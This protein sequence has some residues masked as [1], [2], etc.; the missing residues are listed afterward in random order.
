VYV[1]IRGCGVRVAMPSRISSHFCD[2]V[3]ARMDE[4]LVVVS[5]KVDTCLAACN[6]VRSSVR[7][8][9]LL[10]DVILQVGNSLNAGTSRVC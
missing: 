3:T 2:W 10:R 7:F 6:E 5:E 4:K 1:D 8:R 9:Q